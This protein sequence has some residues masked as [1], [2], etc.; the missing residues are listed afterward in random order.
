MINLLCFSCRLS[1]WK[2]QE[3]KFSHTERGTWVQ[4]RMSVSR[5]VTWFS[6]SFLA[7]Q[8]NSFPTLPLLSEFLLIV[9]RSVSTFG[10]FIPVVDSDSVINVMLI[11]IS[12]KYCCTVV[13]QTNGIQ[14]VRMFVSLFDVLFL[15][16]LRNKDKYLNVMEVTTLIAITSQYGDISKTRI[17]NLGLAIKR[18][19]LPDPT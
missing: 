10:K 13:W 11:E 15:F 6:F 18:A 2:R 4:V 1:L 16:L 12:V 14:C 17:Y 3:M 9:Y 8:W 19:V 5:S 7:G